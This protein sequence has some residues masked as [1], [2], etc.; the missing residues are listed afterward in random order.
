MRSQFLSKIFLFFILL[1]SLIPILHPEEQDLKKF[2]SQTQEYLTNKNIPA[3]L[4][5]FSPEIRE[6]EKMAIKNLFQELMMES[7]VF[8]KAK[9]E[10]QKNGK[11]SVNALVFY[12]ND[13]SAIVESWHLQMAQ[14]DENWQIVSK[15]V[16][17]NLSYKL[18]IPSSHIEK[19]QSIEVKHIDIKLNF[20]NALIF[21]DNIPD[22]ETALVIIGE[23]R[24]VFRPSHP[25]EQHQLQLIYSDKILQDNL[26]YAYLRFS[27]DFFK[28]NITIERLE[29]KE[30]EV[31]S[32]S[33]I[34]EARDIF[35]HHHSRSFS[36]DHSISG[37]FL[38]SIPQGGQAV[39]TFSADKA[40]ILTYIYSPYA[41]EEVGLLDVEEGNLISLY[42]PYNDKKQMKV[43]FS[44]KQKLLI[45]DYNID[46]HFNPDKSFISGKISID[47][48]SQANSLNKIRFKLN[49]NLDILRIYDGKKNSLF[50]TQDKLRKNLYL[51]L[52]P[53]QSKEKT[54][55]VEIFYKGK[56]EF[57]KKPG[58]IFQE[59]KIDF[60]TKRV[61][62]PRY[63]SRLFSQS[64]YW[65]PS[66]T[67]VDYFRARL[68]VTIPS[69]YKCIG[70]GYLEKYR[71][72]VDST[73][74][75]S[76]N[77][78]DHSIYTFQT[79][80]P[81]NHL[82]FIVGKFS[83]EEEDLKGIPLEIFI[84]SKIW[85]KN[86]S[87][88]KKSRSI[89]QFYQGLFGPFPYEKLSI[90]RRHWPSKGGH[91]SASFIVLNEFPYIPGKR[92]PVFS[93]SPVD[94][95]GW[96]EYSIAH[97]IAHQW[98]GHGISYASYH[99]KWLSEGLAQ[100]SALL[101]LKKDLG[102]KAFHKMLQKFSHWTEKKSSKGCITLGSRLSHNDFE[103][104]QAIVYNKSSLVLNM[105]KDILGDEVF[106]RGLKDF[107][108]NHKYS[109]VRTKDFMETMEKVSGKDL[110]TFFH[111]WLD[112]HL[113]PEVKISHSFLKT[114]KG[115]D[116]MLKFTQQKNLFIFPLLVDWQEKGKTIQ[117]KIIIDEKVKEFR[118][119]LEEKPDQIKINSDD[120]VPGKFYEESFFG[121]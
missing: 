120:S 52:I 33:E 80:H 6:K 105:L 109:A 16:N 1:Y 44:L 74:E 49:P 55:K 7:V 75:E 81:V 53:S 10:K 98:W 14:A 70:T 106:F 77:E 78:N 62:Y 92:R 99:D 97:E 79:K 2:I 116:L 64:I 111:A 11:A 89:L 5:A 19:V 58:I 76:K 22:L 26:K 50:Y 39:F 65:Y 47:L 101:Y 86:I 94:F 108:Q 15:E 68:K 28:K 72:S 51:Y 60:H 56:L 8:H 82:S 23:G 43:S 61:I 93:R 119:H 35:N 67:E 45:K 100:F 121:E 112:T 118:F 24:T 18:K 25:R 95:S 48:E 36:F 117:K 31:I 34:S 17:S 12:Q 41:Q 104:Y 85:L 46:I 4:N 20:E 59:S 115:Y 87:F 57:P 102:D 42:S 30:S 37:S 91:S 27:N 29:K 71:H 13:F 54:Q 3:Y 40:G 113:L 110:S 32:S 9:I 103:A 107:F 66:P 73:D 90:V 69:D 63:S 88:L 96:D 114:D 83:K 21:Y 84:S 38:S